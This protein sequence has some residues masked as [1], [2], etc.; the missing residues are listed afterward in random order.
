MHWVAP[1]SDNKPAPTRVAPTSGFSTPHG[2][3]GT[4]KWR[5]SA[6]IGAHD[7]EPGCSHGMWSS[8]TR[9]IM[10]PHGVTKYGHPPAGHINEWPSSQHL[11]PTDDNAGVRPVTQNDALSPNSPSGRTAFV[12]QTCSPPTPTNVF[13]SR[14]GTLISSR[15]A[16]FAYWKLIMLSPQPVSIIM[17]GPLQ[18]AAP[19]CA[20]GGTPD[21]ILSDA[22]ATSQRALSSDSCLMKSLGC[23]LDVG[24]RIRQAPR[25]V[26][27]CGG[28][29]MALK[30]STCSSP[31]DACTGHTSSADIAPISRASAMARILA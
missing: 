19:D 11:L 8:T 27:T 9:G 25:R 18:Q 24:V 12:R 3:S 17:R 30:T 14:A 7:A 22:H 2:G 31:H 13:P 21:F 16:A 26:P 6:L 20:K 28:A 10:V 4:F 23:I 5:A 15:P 29:S 1:A